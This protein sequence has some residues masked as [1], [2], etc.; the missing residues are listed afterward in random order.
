MFSILFFSILFY[1]ILFF[2]SVCKFLYFVHIKSTSVLSKCCWGC[3]RHSWWFKATCRRYDIFYQFFII[4]GIDFHIFILDLLRPIRHPIPYGLLFR[5]S[6]GFLSTYYLLSGS[7]G[8]FL[9]L[10]KN[11]ILKQKTTFWQLLLTWYFT[12]RLCT[13]GKVG[14]KKMYQPT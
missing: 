14:T 13:V 3:E 8:H 5:I 2:F 1:S 7:N 6:Q 4:V 9:G 12:N 11:L 10:K